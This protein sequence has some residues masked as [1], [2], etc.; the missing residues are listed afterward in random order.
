MTEVEIVDL[1]AL[2]VG[3]VRGDLAH[4][5][6]TWHRFGEIVD[7]TKIDEE[8]GVA[9]AALLPSEVMRGMVSGGPEQV[10]YEAALVVPEGI[11][12]P[13]GLVEGVVPAGRYA[14]MV[15]V[16]PY[17]GLAGAWQ[18]FTSEWLPTSGQSVGEGLCYEV[19]R[20]RPGSVQASQYRTELHIPMA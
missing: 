5:M 16:G 12:L 1:P 13:N 6:E 3:V 11:A 2:R 15:Y 10:R 19:Y 14:R 8:P 18:E 4:A 20:N 17:E 9:R 7:P